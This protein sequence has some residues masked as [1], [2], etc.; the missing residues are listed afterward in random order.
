[1]RLKQQTSTK[2]NYRGES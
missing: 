2:P 1:M